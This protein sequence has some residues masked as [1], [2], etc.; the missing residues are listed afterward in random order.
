MSLHR[1]VLQLFNSAGLYKGTKHL[2]NI[3]KV[4]LLPLCPGVIF[5]VHPHGLWIF[6]SFFINLPFTAIT[7]PVWFYSVSHSLQYQIY[8]LVLLWRWKSLWV[9]RGWGG[10]LLI[11]TAR[12]W[13]GTGLACQF[14]CQIAGNKPRNT[15]PANKVQPPQSERQQL[16]HHSQKWW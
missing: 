9:Q 10:S 12:L 1:A 15:S 3:V 13:F 4:T 5:Q 7:A 6:A 11:A 16:F 2:S 14:A 8:L